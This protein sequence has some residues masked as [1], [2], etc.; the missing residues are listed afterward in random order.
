M[1]TILLLWLLL[2]DPNDLWE[3]SLEVVSPPRI[4]SKFIYI[5]LIILLLPLLS[6]LMS[7]DHFLE[8]LSAAVA[9]ADLHVSILRWV[10]AAQRI[11]CCHNTIFLYDITHCLSSGLLKPEYWPGIYA[12]DEE[13]V[14]PPT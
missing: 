5:C 2:A 7:D 9:S 14:V 10:P 1:R 12:P 3:G 11:I 6:T 4:S 13:D 8:S